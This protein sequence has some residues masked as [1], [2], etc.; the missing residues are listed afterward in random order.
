MAG[1]VV[2]GRAGVGPREGGGMRPAHRRAQLSGMTR[3]GQL[4]KNSRA[5]DDT[6]SRGLR[7]RTRRG[8]WSLEPCRPRTA[9]LPALRA[10]LVRR[11]ARAILCAPGRHR[12]REYDT[13]GERLQDFPTVALSPNP[14]GPIPHR[15]PSTSHAPQRG[16]VPGTAAPSTTG[17]DEPRQPVRTR[18]GEGCGRGAWLSLKK[19]TVLRPRFCLLP[20]TVIFCVFG[21]FHRESKD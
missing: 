12:Q 6:P 18:Q 2:R 7:V 21:K 17:R 3:S 10:R 5:R 9:A 13:N 11:N 14:P 4:R 15:P 8:G 16:R 19:I 20:Y 1:H